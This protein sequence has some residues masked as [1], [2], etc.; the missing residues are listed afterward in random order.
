MSPDECTGGMIVGGQVM[1]DPELFRLNRM[2]IQV[3]RNVG[4]GQNLLMTRLAALTAFANG[5]ASTLT[6]S[7]VDNMKAICA[8]VDHAIHQFGKL[9]EERDAIRADLDE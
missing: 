3:N 2:M 5:D 8:D 9:L 1:K 6:S 7:D 4:R